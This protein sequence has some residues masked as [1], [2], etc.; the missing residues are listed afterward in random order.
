MCGCC[1]EKIEDEE[2]K[3]NYEEA[4]LEESLWFCRDC[5]ENPPTLKIDELFEQMKTAFGSENGEKFEEFDKSL[6]SAFA[7]KCIQDGLIEGGTA[8]LIQTLRVI[9]ASKV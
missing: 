9:T 1:G 8:G 7:L 4:N 3:K 2:I 6:K 5:V